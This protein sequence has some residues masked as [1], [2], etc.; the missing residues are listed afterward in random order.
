MKLGLHKAKKFSSD[1]GTVWTGPILALRHVYSRQWGRKLQ[2]DV[3]NTGHNE[4]FEMMPKFQL[5][6]TVFKNNISE[7]NNWSWDFFGIH[8]LLPITEG[9]AFITNINLHWHIFFN[10]LRTT[11][12]DINIW[13]HWAF[14]YARWK[15]QRNPEHLN[16]LIICSSDIFR[17]FY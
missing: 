12:V 15:S 14:K 11:H 6:T 10:F 5:I 3:I 1:C 4:L 2:P 16:K 13:E 7:R 9:C 8:V 17:R